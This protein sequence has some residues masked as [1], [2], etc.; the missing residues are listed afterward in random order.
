MS[1]SDLE[2]IVEVYGDGDCGI[3]ASALHEV[4]GLPLVLFR[5]DGAHAL[6]L[7]DR[8]PRHA[9]VGLPDGRFLD[10]AGV[11]VKTEIAD[12]F[13]CRFLV[14]ATPDPE[15]YPFES[16]PG[17]R[18]YDEE[19]WSEACRFAADMLTMRGLAYLL[20]DDGPAVK[21]TEVMDAV[22]IANPGKTPPPR[23]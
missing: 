17:S 12:R 8:W 3:F 14:D 15:A 22:E 10:A 4:T 2:Y 7:P 23:I 16:A 13:E 20:K 1:E 19:Q 18:Y 11:F 5:L 9:A 6:H 21:G